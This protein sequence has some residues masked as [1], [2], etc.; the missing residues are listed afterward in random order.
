MDHRGGADKSAQR[1]AVRPQDHRHIAGKIH[2][3]K[4]VGVIVNIGRMHPRLAAVRA[5]PGRFGADQANTGAAGV[6][7]HL[8]AGRKKVRDILFGKKLRRAMRAVNDP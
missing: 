8:P 4:R 2:G 7:V 1:R 5:R 6:V 3:A